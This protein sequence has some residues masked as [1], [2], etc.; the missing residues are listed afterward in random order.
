MSKWK[1]SE[2][3]YRIG[4]ALLLSLNVCHGDWRGKTVDGVPR[5]FSRHSSSKIGNEI[6]SRVERGFQPGVETTLFEYSGSRLADHCRLS[7]KFSAGVSCCIDV[8]NLPMLPPGR[9]MGTWCSVQPW[10]M[11]RCAISRQ[12][13]YVDVLRPRTC[14]FRTSSLRTKLLRPNTLMRPHHVSWLAL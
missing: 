11:R 3:F 13:L 6:R 14:G 5:T 9:M 1:E 10:W 4:F 7:K 12:R 8:D 2:P